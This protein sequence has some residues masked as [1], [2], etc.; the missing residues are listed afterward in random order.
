MRGLLVVVCGCT[1][2]GSIALCRPE[3]PLGSM[4]FTSET[5]VGNV[6]LPGSVVYSAARRTYRVTGCGNNMW[7][8][9]DD[10]YYVWRRVKGDSGVEIEVT[11]M[12][13]G[14]TEDRK[15]AWV[16]RAGLAKDDPYVDAVDHARGLLC[17]QYRLV[18]GGTTLEVRSPIWAPVRP[19]G[20][21]SWV[22]HTWMI[23]ERDGNQFTM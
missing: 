22:P 11:W 23:L 21:T 1:M 14:K 16:I 15:A 20:I 18:K 5:N 13:K 19:E 7:F 10:F 2:M 3:F 9:E 6:K 4:K 17:L 12:G 8:N